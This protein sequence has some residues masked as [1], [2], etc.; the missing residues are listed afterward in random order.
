MKRKIAV[1]SG[2]FDPVTLGHLDLIERASKIFDHLIVSVFINK[3]KH[4]LF[5]V[6]KR[7]EMIK[8][9]LKN[10]PNVTVDWFEGLLVD[11]MKKKKI[12][13]VIRGLRAISDLDYEFQ[14]AATNRTLYPEIETVFLMPRQRY[15]YLS[16]SVVRDVASFRGD[17]S[18]LV[19]PNVAKEL[20]KIF[21]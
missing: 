13:V 8:T 21:E 4:Y 20:K 18:K 5:P 6:E 14:I 9:A 2:S 17:V 1:Y 3:S 10:K 16:S 7:V 11:Y 15:T 19:T 12:N